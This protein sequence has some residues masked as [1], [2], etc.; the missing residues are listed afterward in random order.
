MSKPELLKMFVDQTY[1]PKPK[2]S[3]D[4]IPDLSGK[5]ILITGGN[6]G[7]GEETAR[8]SLERVQPFDSRLN[9]IPVING[10][11]QVVLSRNAK[12]YITSRSETNGTAAMER[13]KEKTGKTDIYCLS[14]DLSSFESIR[15]AA[16]E[17][18]NKEDKLDV[19]FNNA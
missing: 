11:L 5:T 17:L 2:F 15:K 1:P 9:L 7:I 10:A 14:L 13:L 16:E 6:T 19:L 12:V 3:E 8:V 18:K 4:G